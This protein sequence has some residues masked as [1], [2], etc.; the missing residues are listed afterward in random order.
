MKLSILY[1]F[2]T[3]FKSLEKKIQQLPVFGE[4]GI[5]E[6]KYLGTLFKHTVV[7]DVTFL[8]HVY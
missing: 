5:E 3:H 1:T 4:L 7:G 8:E 2:L 6:V